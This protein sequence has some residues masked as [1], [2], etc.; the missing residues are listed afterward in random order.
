VKANSRTP[1]WLVALAAASLCVI[2]VPV[3]ADEYPQHPIHLV[4]PYAPGGTTDLAGRIVGKALGETLHQSV[5]AE[6]KPGA[7]G[8]LGVFQVLRSAP[9][10]Y[11]AAVSGVSPTM[12]HQLLGRK[13]PY[14]PQKEINAVGYLGSSGMVVI[15]RKDSPYK[16]LRQVIEQS[17][18]NPGSISF[19]SAGIASPGHLATEYLANMAGI[20]MTHVPY[21]GDAAL[22][23]D[24]TT[25][26]IDIATVGIAS[27]F[28]HMQAGTVTALALTSRERIKSFPD[29]PTVAEAGNLLG[30]EADIWNLLV[31]PK[32]T[33][34]DVDT[35]LNATINTV[36]SDKGVQE[37][38]LR[39]GFTGRPMSL[40]E[41]QSFI[42]TERDKW[43][44]VIRDAKIS[45]E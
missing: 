45:I 36:M 39:I 21:T 15:T 2:A 28:S 22:M 20:H 43:A 25:G 13:L 14:D 27:V 31:V 7:A 24:L 37:E 17:K 11:T 3:C 10:G 34:A 19:G 4:V 29:M 44:K 40:P 30:Y 38:L 1:A 6:N 8:S 26:R 33:P 41:V 42:Q 16:T 18:V 32:G 5:I 35:K 23:G 12:L 9:D